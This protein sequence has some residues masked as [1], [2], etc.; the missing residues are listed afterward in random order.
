[1]VL[2]VRT[3][4]SKITGMGKNI[5]NGTYE[6]YGGDR[7]TFDSGSGLCLR[8]FYTPKA[9]QTERNFGL[10]GFGDGSLDNAGFR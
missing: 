7:N 6:Y 3:P 9:S 1:M 2:V 8:F 4:Q 5:S 10:S